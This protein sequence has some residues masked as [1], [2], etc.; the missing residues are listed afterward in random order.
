MIYLMP[1][2]CGVIAIFA[3][4]L[5]MLVNAM[6]LYGA[7]DFLVWAVREL[8]PRPAHRGP[9]WRTCI[10]GGAAFAATGSV[11]AAAAAA[12]WLIAVLITIETR[13]L[14]RYYPGHLP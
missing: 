4:P 12:T 14:M 2:A 13:R 1:L 9:P 10:V 3:A 6:G 5:A 11:L 7:H 8:S